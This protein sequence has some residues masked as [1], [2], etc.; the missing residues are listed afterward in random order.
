V[1]TCIFLVKQ[2]ESL[3]VAAEN[4]RIIEENANLYGVMVKEMKV[5]I[6]KHSKVADYFFI[7]VNILLILCKTLVN[8]H[9]RN[10]Q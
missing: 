8:I 6:S 4:H 2:L 1:G 9:I 3:Y 5:R 10:Y 7:V